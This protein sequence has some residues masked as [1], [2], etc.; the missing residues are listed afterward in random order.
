MQRT[1]DRI[2][3]LRICEDRGIEDYGRLMA[4]QN[5]DRVYERL[6]HLFRQA[7]DRY[8][9]GLFHFRPEKG[10]GGHDDWSLGL[11]IDD[12]VLK[13][14]LKNLYYP[15]SP[16]AFSVLPADILGQVYE[17]FLGKVIRLTQGHRAVVEDKPEVKK[18]GGVL[19]HPT[20]IV[21]YIVEHTVGKLL[22]G[23]TVR[24]AAG[25]VKGGRPL[26]ILDPACGSRSFLI[27]AYQYLLD[28]YLAQYTADK[29]ETWAKRKTP[30]LF[31]DKHGEWRLTTAERKRILLDHIHG[32]DIDAQA[33][34]VTKLSLL[35]KVLEDE[36]AE[37]IGQSRALFHERALP[38]LANNIKCGNSLIGPDFYQG[39][40]VD[41]FD[42][43]ELYRVNGL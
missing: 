6:A 30:V 38:D 2:I 13:A 36:S 37:T 14:I 23:K 20:Y 22:E 32:V 19:L 21:D 3:F 33:V 28:W 40:Q 27:V 31:K 42:E 15:D 29:P 39:R 24:Q 34:E 43:E 8:N 18:A 17:Q 16:Y 25:N 26:R 5:G 35:L 41:A 1:I 4:L 12:K 10:R 9:S 7:D 11:S